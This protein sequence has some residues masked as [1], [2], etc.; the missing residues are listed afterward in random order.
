MRLADFDN[1]ESLL[2]KVAD[3][4]TRHIAEYFNLLG[5]LYEVQLKWRLARKCYGKAMRANKAY[6]PAQVNMRRLYELNTF[7]HS[8]L[9]VMLG[10]EV[11]DVL[12]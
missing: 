8:A 12:D 9:S 5:V 6:Q 11:M 7:G 10:D 2:T 1:A 4:P 3:R